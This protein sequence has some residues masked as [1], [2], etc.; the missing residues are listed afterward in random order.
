MS[1]LPLEI[2][3]GAAYTAWKGGVSMTRRKS[4]K[5][6]KQIGAEVAADLL[7]AF[8]AFCEGR[9]ETLRHHLELA[10]RRHLENP[11]APVAYPPLPPVTVPGAKPAKGK[12]K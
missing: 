5:G 11:P 10:M 3:S 4:T 6:T 8:K 12:K 2:F 9:N 7:D 1:R